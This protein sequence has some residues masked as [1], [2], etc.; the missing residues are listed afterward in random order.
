M[1]ILYCRVST[2]HQNESRQVELAERLGIEKEN[3][4]VDKA[5]GKNTERKALKEMLAFF[6]AAV[7]KSLNLCYLLSAGVFHSLH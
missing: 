7:R 6:Q 1:K 4:Y 2:A 3:I 5:S